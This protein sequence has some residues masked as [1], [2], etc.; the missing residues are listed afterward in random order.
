MREVYVELNIIKGYHKPEL[1]V[2]MSVE[3]DKENVPTSQTQC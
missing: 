1:N 2:E 3:E